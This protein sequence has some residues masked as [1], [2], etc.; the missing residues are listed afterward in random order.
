MHN[1]P[2][3]TRRPP[4]D[5]LDH[6]PEAVTQAREEA[7]LTK[8]ELAKAIGCVES[9]IGEIERGTRNATPD[10]LRR[11]ADALNCPVVALERKRES[12]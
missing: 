11:I 5:P 6:E 4:K 2:T 9:L 1:A 7:G 10:R 8:R 12:T 3:T